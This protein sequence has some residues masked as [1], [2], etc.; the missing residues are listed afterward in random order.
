MW[1]G[2]L[3]RNWSTVR[4]M[5]LASVVAW[6]RATRG[7]YYHARARSYTWHL[8]RPQGQTRMLFAME[9]KITAIPPFMAPSLVPKFKI[10]LRKWI[11]SETLHACDPVMQTKPGWSSCIYPEPIKP[12][13]PTVLWAKRHQCKT[14]TPISVK[15]SRRASLVFVGVVVINRFCLRTHQ[16]HGWK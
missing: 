2:V 12:R 7:I 5:K 6:M 1:H 14:G 9:A 10:E 11:T 13:G 4:I 15:R 16:R 8:L 3:Y